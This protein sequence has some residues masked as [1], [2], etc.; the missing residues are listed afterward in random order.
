[1]LIFYY[2]FMMSAK[3]QF[4]KKLHSRNAPQGERFNNKA[5]ADIAAFSSGNDAVTG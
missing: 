5:Q 4:L 3:E 2:G 1:M